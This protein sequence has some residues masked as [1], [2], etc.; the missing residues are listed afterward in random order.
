MIQPAQLRHL[1]KISLADLKPV[2]SAQNAIELLMLTAAQE[3]HCGS[4]LWQDDGD[5][6]IE[7]HLAF[8]IYQMEAIGYVQAVQRLSRHYPYSRIPPRKHIIWDLKAATILA[9]AYYASW[10]EPLPPW[11]DVEGLARYWKKYWNTEAGKGRVE[12]AIR[13][14]HRYAQ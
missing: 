6:E 9:R 7:N 12:D 4:Y 3:S 14:Y 5:P 10:P 11:D 8:G 13:N 2:L 1:I